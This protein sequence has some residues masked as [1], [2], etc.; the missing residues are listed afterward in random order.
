VS[1]ASGARPHSRTSEFS[2]PTNCDTIIWHLAREKGAVIFTKDFDFYNRALLFGAPP[3]VLH[4][5]VGNC[6][7][8]RLLKII[9]AAWLEVE[10]ALSDGSKLISVSQDKVEIFP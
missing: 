4:I 3:P 1:L 5:G 2:E 6:S 10:T 8:A 9:D 7:T